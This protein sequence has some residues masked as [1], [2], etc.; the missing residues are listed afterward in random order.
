MSNRLSINILY[1]NDSNYHRYDSGNCIFYGWSVK[2]RF[3]NNR[4]YGIGFEYRDRK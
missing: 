3:I 2:A 4:L 1:V